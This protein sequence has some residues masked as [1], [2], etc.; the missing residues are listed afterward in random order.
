MLPLVEPWASCPGC[1]S[2]AEAG[3]RTAI[4]ALHLIPNSKPLVASPY[5][6]LL[7]CETCGL[8]FSSPRPDPAAAARYYDAAADKDKGWKR[9]EPVDNSAK[10]NKK[11][12]AA[13]AALAPFLQPPRQGRRRALDYGCGAGAMLDVL[14]DAGWETVGVE[15]SRIRAYSSRR[16]EIVDDIPLDAAFDLVIVHHVLEHVVDVGLLLQQL[17]A[18]AGPAGQL[19]IGVPSLTA[20]AVT[21][22]LKYACSAL[23]INSFTSES[24]GNVLRVNGWRPASADE[25]SVR[26]RLLVHAERSDVPLPPNAGGLDAAARALRDYGRRLDARGEFTLCPLD[27]AVW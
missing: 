23:H 19:L 25:H 8:V 27:S 15:P 3:G 6:A 4:H 10:M 12:A 5:L 7:G 21:G 9:D 14:Q 1:G 22:D 16:H 17:H 24:L 13:A 26:N 18:A 20:V 11:H 2:A